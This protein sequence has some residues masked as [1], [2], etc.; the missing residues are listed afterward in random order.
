M[1]LPNYAVE[2]GTRYWDTLH[3]CLLMKLAA[4]SFSG[5]GILKKIILTTFC[6]FSRFLTFGYWN[7]VLNESD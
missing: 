2:G 1:A 5:N 6:G 3:I 4:E 7:S